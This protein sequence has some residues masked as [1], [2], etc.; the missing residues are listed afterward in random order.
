MNFKHFLN[1]KLMPSQFRDIVKA[2]KRSGVRKRFDHVFG[3]KDR[4]YEPYK[5]LSVKEDMSMPE[6]IDDAMDAVNVIDSENQ[7]DA[8]DYVNGLARNTKTKRLIKFMKLF[9]AS[10]KKLTEL[11]KISNDKD[12]IGNYIRK[13]EKAKDKFINDK[14]RAV[15]G[16]REYLICYSRHAYDIAGMSTD[17]GWESCMELPGKNKKEG[18]VNWEYIPKEVKAGTIIAYLIKSDDKNIEKPV[19]RMLIRPYLN[20]ETW[21]VYMVACTGG[22]GT[23]PPEFVE[24]VKKWTEKLNENAPYGDYYFQKKEME[25][26]Y[27]D[28]SYIEHWP[29]NVQ[30]L[31]KKNPNI[32]FVQ[33]FKTLMENPNAFIFSKM[34]D[35]DP[36]YNIGKDLVYDLPNIKKT[37]EIDDIIPLFKTNRLNGYQVLV[38]L[39]GRNFGVKYP[40]IQALGDILFLVD[41]SSKYD[42]EPNFTN[43]T[44]FEKHLKDSNLH[45]NYKTIYKE[46]YNEFFS[47]VKKY[48]PIFQ[49][50]LGVNKNKNAPPVPTSKP[51]KP[52]HGVKYET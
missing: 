22:Y 20:N 34:F 5:G 30:D 17:R 7:Y 49:D 25:G 19:G 46:N 52:S 35:N 4:L 8:E 23:T 45:L 40:K 41:T 24:Q 15:K 50:I 43:K 21:D 16:S 42:F 11:Q 13:I 2:W 39:K 29:D 28:D 3:S 44:Q 37:F 32:E 51:T 48:F 26:T 6:W 1:E 36:D 10:I 12:R 47:L 31:K 9:D 27:S 14:S 18:G 38:K 33:D